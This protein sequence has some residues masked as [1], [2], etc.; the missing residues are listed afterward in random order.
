MKLRNKVLQAGILGKDRYCFLSC[1]P[2]DDP[3]V[4]IYLLNTMEDDANYSL[5]NVTEVDEHNVG[6]SPYKGENY[7][8]LVEELLEEFVA[9]AFQ[10]DDD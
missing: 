7:K 3:K 5:W 9:H 6:L 8:E 1:K 10:H 4:S 2:T